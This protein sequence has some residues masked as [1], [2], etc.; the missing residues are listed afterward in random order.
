MAQKVIAVKMTLDAGQTV[1]E[2][3]NVEQGLKGV[4]EQ[5][6]NI[7]N[8][9]KQLS[10]TEKAFA[11]LNKKVESGEMTMRQMA[12]AVKE[13]QTIAIQSGK[14]SP[15]GQEALSKAAALK[16]ELGD[17]STQV[18]NLGHDGQNMQ[19]A[20]QLGSTVIGGYSAFQGITAALGVENEEL[21]QTFVKLQAAQSA[22]AGIEQIRA[23]LE[24]E[25]F[26]MLKA[27]TIQTNIMSAAQAVYS[28]VVGTSTGALKLF[29]IALISTGIG[30]II[31]GIGLLIA[32][33]DKLVGFV[34]WA[35][36]E[37]GNLR[38][39]LLLLA[40]PIGWIILAYQKLYSEEAKLA[41]ARERAAAELRKQ[42]A[43]NRKQTQERINQIKEQIKAEQEAE[44]RR[45]EVFDLEIAR[46]EAEG[47]SSKALKEQ[48]LNDALEFARKQLELNEALIQS[49]VDY[50]KR[51]AQLQGMSEQ[52]FIESMRRQGVDLVA[53]QEK[54]NASLQGMRDNIYAAETDLIAFKNESK[55]GVE[56]NFKFPPP[57][58]LEKGFNDM[59]EA[60]NYISVEDFAIESED[61]I[62]EEE[63]QVAIG[64]LE[65]FF[66][67]LK[68]Y[69]QTGSENIKAELAAT[70]QATQEMAN[71][72]L[73]TLTAINDFANQIGDNRAKKIEEQK[74]RELNVEGLTAKQKYDIELK[75]AKAV[76]EI[77]KRQFNREKALNI[78]KA[79]MD[80]ASAVVKALASSPPPANF[81]L[82]GLVGAAGVAQIATIAAQKFEGTAANLTP[83]N[84]SAAG[85]GT[86]TG[87]GSSSTN[88][89]NVNPNQGGYTETDALISKVVLV[90]SDVTK[91]QQGIAKINAIATL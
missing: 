77:R 68:M 6:E 66:T 51:Q 54:A 4:D 5:I 59:T 34:K 79:T 75:A 49:Y 7:N 48:K 70:L 67:K 1:N 15:I 30:A 83:P 89:T 21:A 23:N 43:E 11:E 20:L 40:G 44:N 62:P 19:A 2:I 56:V 25:S 16:D 27:R 84:F 46:L 50:Y 65:E 74:K 55:K 58:E 29:R 78:A 52:E 86:D 12:K 9:S 3:E 87:S 17:L 22:L 60:L 37:F 35:I 53:L 39:V 38:D 26:M 91:M 90:E 18:N 76:D 80:S 82:A 33:F 41:D 10:Q 31:V 42:T 61:L 85:S 88:T 45:Q 24:K 81:V 47:K 28:T 57:E 14:D 32:N 13:Y 64:K 8:D 71:Q 73:D 63:I 36:N 72:A 69:R